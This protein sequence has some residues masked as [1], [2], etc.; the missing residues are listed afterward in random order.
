MND[1]YAVLGLRRGASEQEAK[2]AF[3][4]LAKS[5]HP[6]L[7]PN[8]PAAEQ[9]F[10]DINAAYDAIRNPQPDPPPNPFRE[11]RFGFGFGTP[12][13]DFFGDAHGFNRQARNPDTHLECRIT[14][15]EAFEGKEIAIESP[16]PI[17]VRI[18]AGIEDGIRLRVP[19]AGEQLNQSFRPGDLYVLIRVMPHPTLVRQGRNLVTRLSVTAFDV[20]LN[21]DVEV[22]GIDGHRVRVAIPAGF[23]TTRKLRLTGQGMPDGMGR[24]DLLIELIV[25]FPALT[26]EQRAFIDQAE[27][28]AAPA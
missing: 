14:L 11:F 25:T 1:P 3:R 21:K 24:G 2:E 27:R 5:C 12:F 28:T 23:D 7:H 20:L 22:E 6:D 9:R 18:P 8:D 26:D 13:D 16:R 17:K 10:K 15:R 4:K 19:Q